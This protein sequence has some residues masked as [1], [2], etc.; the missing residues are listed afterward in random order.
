[1]VALWD[2]KTDIT[3]SMTARPDAHIS[4]KG[5]K[6]AQAENLWEHRSRLLIPERARLNTV[7]AFS[8]IL[9]ERVLG[10]AWV[11][12][13]PA[14]SGIETETLER[15]LCAYINSSV[16]ALAMLVDRSNTTPS[17]PR[18]SLDDLRKLPVPDFAALGPAAVPG[19]AAAYDRQANS[20]LRP[21]PQ[22]NDCPARMA[23]DAAVIAALGLDEELVANIRRQLA[24][25]PS[26]TGQRY[27]GFER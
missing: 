22:L 26:V 24:R 1:M 7:R 18:F 25:E 14:V 3:Q 6:K 17:Y 20:V 8:V 13:R 2:Y 16:G 12:C 9:E 23:L 10:S 21:L 27:G 15:A 5:G 4:P 19:L 11:P